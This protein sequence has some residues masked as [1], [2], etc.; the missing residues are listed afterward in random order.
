MLKK[1]NLDKFTGFLSAYCWG[2]TVS[3][4]CSQFLVSAQ[5]FGPYN[6][7]VICHMRQMDSLAAK[8][9]TTCGQSLLPPT[10]G[11]SDTCR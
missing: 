9:L 1:K 6:K 11:S 2:Y 5:G 10:Y 3:L 7:E 8:M 4:A